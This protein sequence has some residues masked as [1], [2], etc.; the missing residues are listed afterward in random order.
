MVKIILLIVFSVLAIAAY[1]LCKLMKEQQVVS[2]I[3]AG[4]SV[5]MLIAVIICSVLIK[6]DAGK[7]KQPTSNEPLNV[8]GTQ[9]GEE[10]NE[11]GVPIED[12]E[13]PL[14][15]D[16]GKNKEN[17]TTTDE[18]DGQEKTKD[19]EEDKKEGNTGTSNTEKEEESDP[20]NTDKSKDKDSDNKDSQDSKGN[21]EA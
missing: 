21:D 9:N 12:T 17:D 19:S 13:K 15:L 4:V 11:Q 8:E 2:L 7:E 16:G 20:K 1:I 14:E 3:M 18:S 10:S 5:A 6:M